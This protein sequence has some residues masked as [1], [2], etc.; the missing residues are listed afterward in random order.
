[1]IDLAI[2]A[3]KLFVGVVLLVIAAAAVGGEERSV[4]RCKVGDRSL[5][6]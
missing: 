2:I 6:G 1:M 4:E 3:L 5:R